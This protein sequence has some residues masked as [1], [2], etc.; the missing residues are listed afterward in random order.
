MG[1]LNNIDFN[2]L[3]TYW[4]DLKLYNTMYPA[5]S[6]IWLVLNAEVELWQQKLKKFRRPGGYH[7]LK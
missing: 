5:S 1:A 7:T 3:S 4:E 2:L 6:I